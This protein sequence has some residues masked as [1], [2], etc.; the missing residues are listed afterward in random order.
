MNQKR[1]SCKPTTAKE[2]DRKQMILE[3]SLR[4]KNSRRNLI[5]I[6]SWIYLM[7]MAVNWPVVLPINKYLDCISNDTLKFN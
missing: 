1:Y 3:T 5:L 6:S 7:M 2:K 4:G